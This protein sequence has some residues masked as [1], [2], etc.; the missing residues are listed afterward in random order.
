MSVRSV[1]PP[2]ARTSSS[3]SVAVAIA[4]G[5]ATAFVTGVASLLI[6]VL[7]VGGDDAVL[8]AMG[9]ALT[10]GALAM[11][12]AWWWSRRTVAERA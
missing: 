10:C 7:V 5:A 8:S 1:A 11:P 6:A 4:V 9:V 2:P 3:A 12:I